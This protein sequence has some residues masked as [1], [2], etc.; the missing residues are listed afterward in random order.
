LELD[1]ELHASGPSALTD[2]E[3]RLID[4]AVE[5]GRV[6]KV[7]MNTTAID[8][9]KVDPRREIIAKN[10]RIRARNAKFRRAAMKRDT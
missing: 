10:Y 4:E 3:R 5:Q 8:Y 9:S 1:K 2:E 6:T 7:P